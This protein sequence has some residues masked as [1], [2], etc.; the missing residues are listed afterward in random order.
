MTLKGGI[1]TLIFT[2]GRTTASDPQ[3]GS[4]DPV[5]VVSEGEE[6]KLDDSD[7]SLEKDDMDVSK[8]NIISE[9]SEVGQRDKLTGSLKE[10]DDE[11]GLPGPEDGTSKAAA[12]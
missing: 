3:A 6:T 5:P 4:G 9:G 7:A 12:Q 11:E 10:P 8:D 2:A 1:L